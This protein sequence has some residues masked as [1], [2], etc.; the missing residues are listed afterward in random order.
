MLTK[1]AVVPWAEAPNSVMPAATN[2]KAEPRIHRKRLQVEGFVRILAALYDPDQPLNI[3][4]YG[5]W[6]TTYYNCIYIDCNPMSYQNN[7]VRLFYMKVRSTVFL[8]DE[9]WML[10]IIEIM[11]VYNG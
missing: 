1:Y 4:D 9:A 11:G 6:F 3:V 5:Y 2:W 8:R 7:S 10:A